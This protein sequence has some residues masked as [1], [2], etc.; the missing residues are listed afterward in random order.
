MSWK[1]IGKKLVAGSVKAAKV[2]G[3]SIDK[4]G[5]WQDRQQ[6]KELKRLRRR[7]EIAKQKARI[8]KYKPKDAWDD[9]WDI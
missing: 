9:G 7:A 6:E 3:E 8:R 4:F 2:T 5:A 1:N